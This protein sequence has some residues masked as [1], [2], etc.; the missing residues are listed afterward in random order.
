[1]A[2]PTNTP[3]FFQQEGL[4]NDR[5]V[6][7]TYFVKVGGT[8]RAISDPDSI[9]K[10]YGNVNFQGIPDTGGSITTGG[11]VPLQ[12]SLDQLAFQQSNNAVNQAAEQRVAQSNAQAPVAST[13]APTDFQKYFQGELAKGRAA[14]D[15]LS[16]NPFMAG[17]AQ[18]PTQPVMNT[19]QFAAEFQTKNKRPPTQEELQ[20]FTL[21]RSAGVPQAPQATTPTASS[22]AGNSI[23]D[24]LSSTKQPTDFASRAKLAASNGIPN[25]TGTAE[26][27]LQLLNKLRVAPPTKPAGTITTESLQKESTLNIGETPTVTPDATISSSKSLLNSIDE[28]TAI[29]QAKETEASKSQTQLS[30]RVNKLLEESLGRT[31]MLNEEEKK[32]GVQEF[33]ANLKNV[34]N[35]I[36]TKT[37]AYEKLYA[38]IAGKPITMNSII[39]ADAQAR[40]VAQSD[41]LFLNSQAQAMQNNIDF[42]KQTAKDAVD[43]KYGPID[44][45]ISI[46]GKQLALLEPTLD[47]EEKIRAQAVTMALQQRKE[48][49]DA[50]K[51]KENT[52]T[53]FN[54]NMIAKYPSAGIR[55]T[56]SYE[57]TQQKVVQSAEYKADMASAT[58]KGSGGGSASNKI[59]TSSNIPRDIKSD[60]ISD[61]ASGATANQLYTA[62]PEV[63]TDYINS[64]MGT[65]EQT[66]TTQPGTNGGGSTAQA[67]EKEVKWWNPLTWF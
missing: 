24:Y 14:G 37:A 41:L 57:T 58:K 50:V 25:Y 10:L 9:Q 63:N 11:A 56:D 66:S 46:L 65:V 8:Y 43:A 45:E 29:L 20:A 52:L 5:Q 7:K 4:T 34:R 15:I 60:L 48:A 40:R 62:Y 36:A 26:Q 17:G 64:L 38:D 44:E 51:E 30:Q 61:I 21:N 47:K 12:T 1:M 59:Y 42:A 39:G 2:L 55:T 22:Y 18:G 3:E 31:G 27:N 6:A 33:A 53:D 28:N 13:V 19:T 54:I 67:P 49:L 23:V 16:N 35:E 32:A